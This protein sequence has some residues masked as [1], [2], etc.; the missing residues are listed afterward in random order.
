MNK[1]NDFFSQL[2][3]NVSDL[4][5]NSPAAD[6]EKNMKAFM[7][8]AFTRMDLL[9]R[10]EFDTQMALLERALARIAALEQ[11]VQELESQTGKSDS[12]N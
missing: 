12:Q 1:P 5:A 9:T 4:I 11:R 2:Q 6:L 10:D 7:G 3:Q 8:Q